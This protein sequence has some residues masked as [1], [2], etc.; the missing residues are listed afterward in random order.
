MAPCRLSES[1]EGLQLSS[2]LYARLRRDGDIFEWVG[3]SSALWL[4]LLIMN[5]VRGAVKIEP[6]FVKL[7]N[8]HC[9]NPSPGNGWWRH[10]RLEKGS[11][12]TI[13]FLHFP[14]KLRKSVTVWS[15]S[16]HVIRVCRN[17]SHSS[18]T[19][20]LIM[21]EP[22]PWHYQYYTFARNLCQASANV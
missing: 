15:T 8:L 4:W 19:L 14:M 5:S 16:S 1:A 11:A 3:S 13:W 7:K 20:R 2:A 22:L 9:L 12:S 21:W 17:S 10:S 18:L 6:G